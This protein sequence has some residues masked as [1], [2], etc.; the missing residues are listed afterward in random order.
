MLKGEAS[1]WFLKGNDYMELA[2]LSVDYKKFLTSLGTAEQSNGMDARSGVQ[3]LAIVRRPVFIMLGLHATILA[4][5]LS[6]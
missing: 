3:M 6:V 4:S 2:L 1:G 5:G